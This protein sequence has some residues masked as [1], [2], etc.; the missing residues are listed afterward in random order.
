[1]KIVKERIE[2][3]KTILPYISK[4]KFQWILLLILKIGQKVPVLIHPLILKIFV[5]IVLEKR[6]LSFMYIVI[7]MCIGAYLL[8]TLLKVSHRVIDNSLFNKIFQ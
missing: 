2:I 1:M 6:N 5:D 7:I 4:Y 8:E 3:F